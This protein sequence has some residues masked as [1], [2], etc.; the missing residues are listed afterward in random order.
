[1]F[2]DVLSGARDDR[3]GLAELIAYVREGGTVVV[4]KLDRLGRNLW[5]ILQ[6]VS[7]VTERGVTVDDG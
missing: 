1:V 3:P 6:T 2:S 5:H 7:D 4:W